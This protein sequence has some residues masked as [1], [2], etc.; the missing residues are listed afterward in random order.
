[1]IIRKLERRE[2]KT[3]KTTKKDKDLFLKSKLR[4]FLGATLS[5]S[6]N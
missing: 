5:F 1:L 2:I 4:V 3:N 6:D